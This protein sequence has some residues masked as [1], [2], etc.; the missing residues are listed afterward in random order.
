MA[1]TPP[2][3][4]RSTSRSRSERSK[5]SSAAAWRRWDLEG[6]GPFEVVGSSVDLEDTFATGRSETPVAFVGEP[7]RLSASRSNLGGILEPR[8]EAT[9]EAPRIVVPKPAKHN[10]LRAKAGKDSRTATGIRSLGHAYLPSSL[11]AA[12]RPC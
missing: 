10:L 12:S 6:D 5:D 7:L 3:K 2:S 4:A 1:A 11:P 8:R 9:L